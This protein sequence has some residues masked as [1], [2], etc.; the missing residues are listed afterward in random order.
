MFPGRILSYLASLVQHKHTLRVLDLDV[1]FASTYLPQNFSDDESDED[2]YNVLGDLDICDEYYC[3]DEA[4]SEGPLRPE[5]IKDGQA[6]DG[7]IGSLR[8]YTSLTQVTISI[9]ALFGDLELNSPVLAKPP[10]IRLI[11]ML[12]SNLEY[13]RLYGYEKGRIRELDDHV[14]ELLGGESKRLPNLKEV[15]GVDN[16]ELGVLPSLATR[17][18]IPKGTDLWKRVEVPL[19]WIEA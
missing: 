15:D 14:N 5:E 6:Y 10:S 16:V 17:I 9:R 7:K 2:E 1:G 13:L 8:H 12:P 11:D 18:R 3:L 4:I 19:G